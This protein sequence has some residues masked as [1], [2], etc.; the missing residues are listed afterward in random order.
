MQ[1]LDEG[2]KTYLQPKCV[3]VTALSLATRELV[4]APIPCILYHSFLRYLTG[5][6]NPLCQAH[7]PFWLSMTWHFHDYMIFHFLLC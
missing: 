5:D 2:Q 1:K 3:V 4:S 6:S 7:F